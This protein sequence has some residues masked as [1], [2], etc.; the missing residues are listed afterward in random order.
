M[1]IELSSWSRHFS[2]I[3]DYMDIIGL[4]RKIISKNIPGDCKDMDFE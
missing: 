2:S 1:M 4:Y 3:S